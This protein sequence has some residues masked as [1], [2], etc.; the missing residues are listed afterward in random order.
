MTKKTRFFAIIAALA[1]IG[2]L[3]AGCDNNTSPTVNVC[4]CPWCPPREGVYCCPRPSSVYEC[5]DSGNCL[6]FNLRFS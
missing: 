1:A 4:E 5:S 2:F 3:T 6:C